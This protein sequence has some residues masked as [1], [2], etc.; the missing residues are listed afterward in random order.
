MGKKI[1]IKKIKDISLWDRFVSN[2]LQGT[3]FST[4]TWLTAGASAAGGEPVM[5]GV[6]DE[7]NFIVG[8]SFVEIKRGPLKKASSPVITPYGGFIYNIDSDNLRSDTESLQLLCAEKLI[9]HLQKKYNYISFVHSPGFVDIRPFSWQNWK[10]SVR[11]TYLLDITDTDKLWGRLRDRA[12]KKIRRAENSLVI[13]DS[14]DTEEIGHMYES[15]FRARNT[16]PPVSREIVTSMV[17]NLRESGL[18][19][20]TTAL[21][22]NGETIA[23]LA[24][25]LDK[26]TVYTW[27]GATYPEKN[28]T[29]ADS[30]LIWNA[31]KNNSD[32]HKYLDM[33]GANIPSIAFF[34]K[35]FGGILTPYYVTERYSSPMS[36][37]AFQ[38]YSKMKRYF[39]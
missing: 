9:N 19:K 12:R 17:S 6:W 15:I 30:L 38:T 25:A 5:L 8:V 34:K 28:Y 36:R 37:T 13:G 27:V 31:I 1:K 2:S 10:E 39:K 22:S 24:L 23:V 4:S 7:D 16:D 14:I 11:Y 3:V 32:T 18:V 33:M 26:N 35:G 21:E 20:I 29:G